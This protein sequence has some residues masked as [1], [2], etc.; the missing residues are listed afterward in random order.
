[1]S[2]SV[3]KKLRI[4]LEYANNIVA[5][6]VE[7]YRPIKYLK[8]KAAKIFYPLNFEVKLL[9]SNKDLSSFD[10]IS[11]GDFFKNKNTIYIKVVQIIAMNSPQKINPKIDLKV[12]SVPNENTKEYNNSPNFLNVNQ[13][14]ANYQDKYLLCDCTMDIIGYYCRVC[15]AFLCKNCRINTHKLHNNVHIETDNLEESVKLYAIS[16]QADINLNLKASKMYSSNFQ[17]EKFVDIASRKE[18]IIRKLDELERKQQ[19]LLNSL[20][21]IEQGAV[22]NAIIDFEHKSA[23]VNQEIESILQN[24]YFSYNKKNKRIDFDQTKKLFTEINS[25]EREFDN[26]TYEVASYKVNFK[27]HKKIDDMYKLIEKAIDSVLHSDFNINKTVDESSLL[28][29][30]MLKSMKN[31]KQK[32]ERP[33]NHL[34]KEKDISQINNSSQNTYKQP[35][36]IKTNINN[37]IYIEAIDKKENDNNEK[38][39]NRHNMKP[40]SKQYISNTMIQDKT[41][42]AGDKIDQIPHRGRTDVILEKNTNFDYAYDPNEESIK[43]LDG[44]DINDED[45]ELSAKASMKSSAKDFG[46]RNEDVEEY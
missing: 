46:K 26:L 44:G 4:S 19:E 11:I 28:S 18:M 24:I 3:V 21:E 20:P 14:G 2:N 40:Y 34:E 42:K 15:N 16:L 22:S 33:T 36:D 12:N 37:R 35:N 27:V 13:L 23:D 31:A 7:P 17:N 39:E 45:K 8:E 32:I 10:N 29:L 9:Y 41:D 1:M 30:E 5:V 25:K 43:N 6:E 38:E